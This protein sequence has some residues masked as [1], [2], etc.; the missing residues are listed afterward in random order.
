MSNDERV[1]L[2]LEYD[3]TVW[4]IVT[5]CMICGKEILLTNAHGGQIYSAPMVCQECKDAIEWAKKR[6]KCNE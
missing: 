5:L 3:K 6:M 2:S 1:D 4:S